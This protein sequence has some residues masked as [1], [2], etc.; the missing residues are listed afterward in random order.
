MIIAVFIVNKTN[1]MLVTVLLHQI[2]LRGCVDAVCVEAHDEAVDV[3]VSVPGE[4][5]DRILQQS[6][7]KSLWSDQHKQLL[8]EI[9]CKQLDDEKYF[10]LYKKGF[11]WCHENYDGFDEE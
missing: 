5:R 2:D 11:R 7:L 6:L 9:E 3:A 10:F 1:F 4:R 8:A